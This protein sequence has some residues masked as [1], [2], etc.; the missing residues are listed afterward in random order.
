MRG[1]SVRGHQQPHLTL[2]GSW[3]GGTSQTK[4]SPKK[5][6]TNGRR[7][8]GVDKLTG[9]DNWVCEGRHTFSSHTRH[10]PPHVRHHVEGLFCGARWVFTG[11]KLETAGDH[12]IP[13]GQEAL[14]CGVGEEKL[15]L[16]RH[17]EPDDINR[18]TSTE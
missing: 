13:H 14:T 4:N 11:G 7:G 16:W 1:G 6:P 3:R 9:G 8:K 12:R 5:S 15:K 18:M 17:Q 10:T 2:G